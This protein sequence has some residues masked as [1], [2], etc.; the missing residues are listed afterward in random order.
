MDELKKGAEQVVRAARVEGMFA[1]ALEGADVKVASAVTHYVRSRG[2][3]EVVEV[4][5][6]DLERTAAWF[7]RVGVDVARG[8]LVERYGEWL[9]AS[10][11]LHG[12]LRA[13]SKTQPWP[14][15]KARGYQTS[16]LSGLKR[17]LDVVS[18]HQLT[19]EQM[20]SEAAEL[21]R[22]GL[23]RMLDVTLEHI[24]SDWAAAHERIEARLVEAGLDEAERVK[25]GATIASDYG[26]C[27]LADVPPRST[28]ALAGLVSGL[29]LEQ[30]ASWAR[31][32][33][34]VRAAS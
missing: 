5:G 3:E 34:R 13:V 9:A 21:T 14:K 11:E 23:A 27:C 4:D 29:T 28:R 19:P 22:R 8:V 17:A 24:A 15:P 31:S 25:F 6:V 26:G 1:A 12:A 30:L 16:Y 2:V 18:M 20:R 33:V 10:R 7:E 32:A